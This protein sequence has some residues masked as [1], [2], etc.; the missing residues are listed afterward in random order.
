MLL[1]APQGSVGLH[2]F[3][4][5]ALVWLFDILCMSAFPFVL[6]DDN[7]P[8]FASQSLNGLLNTAI[9]TS[10]LKTLSIKLYFL[11]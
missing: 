1:Q 11:Y 4:I 6:M 7:L 5:Q 9:N 8:F 10:T 3:G 2:A